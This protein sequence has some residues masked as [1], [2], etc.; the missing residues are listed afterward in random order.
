M[1]QEVPEAHKGALQEL[2]GMYERK[3]NWEARSG[4]ALALQ[5]CAAVWEGED[6][7]QILNFLVGRGVLDDDDTVRSQMVDAGA[8]SL[9][10]SSELR[11]GL[12]FLDVESELGSFVACSGTPHEQNP[13]WLV[14]ILEHAVSNPARSDESA[15]NVFVDLAWKPRWS[16]RARLG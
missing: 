1:A 11:D 16:V 4:T 12:S 9:Q 15:R 8:S 3:R 2:L 6:V 13:A 7:T 5:S 10:P 14:S